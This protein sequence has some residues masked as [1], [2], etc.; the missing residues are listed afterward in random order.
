MSPRS[1][2][3]L[4]AVEG[5]DGAGKSTL[6]RALARALRARG[7]RVRTR[8]EPAD[9]AL[10]ALAQR[11]G[12][13]DSWTG[14]VYFTLD[15]FLARD[16]L[17]RDLTRHAIVLT[18]RSF[19]STLAYQGS[20][21]PARAWS[22]LVELQQVSTIVP[23]RVVLLDLSPREARRRRAAR[24]REAA[25]LEREAIQRRVAREYRRMARQSRW[26]VVDAA[27]PVPQIVGQLVELL[28]PDGA[29]RRRPRRR[30][31]RR[32]R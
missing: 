23:D 1:R 3:R 31:S 17:E 28:A 32:R 16:S 4:V 8:R 27:L 26:I 9:A 20:A 14:A 25:P 5:I 2:G 7:I 15:R 13:A 29:R 12:A 22:R 18:D 30:G 19:Y 11:A 10:G 21:L 6:V 24:S